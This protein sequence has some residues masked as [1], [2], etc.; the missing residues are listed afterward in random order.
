VSNI[1]QSISALSSILGGMAM[2][3][4]QV[5]QRGMIKQLRTIFASQGCQSQ[6]QIQGSSLLDYQRPW[7]P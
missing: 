6:L 1:N 2:F 5:L 3:C 4:L 7:S